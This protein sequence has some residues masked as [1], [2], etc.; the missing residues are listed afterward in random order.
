MSVSSGTWVALAFCF[1][2]E[3]FTALQY[4]AMRKP[5]LK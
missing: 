5:L 4:E 3:V 1:E 2:G